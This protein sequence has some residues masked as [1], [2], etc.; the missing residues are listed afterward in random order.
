MRGAVDRQYIERCPVG[1]DV[2][3]VRTGIGLPEGPLRRCPACA[4]LVSSCSEE[5]YW[6]S[7]QEFDTSTGTLPLPGSEARQRKR[8]RRRL[9]IIETKLGMPRQ[10]IRLL[11]VGCSSGAFLRVAVTDGFQAE[12]VEPAPQAAQAARDAGLLV[13]QGR[14]EDLR[15]PAASFDAITL[16]EV[17]EHLKDPQSLLTECRRLLRGQGL[18]LIGT[19]NADS[20][21]ARLQG[22]RW[23]YFRIDQ[24][25]GHVS[26]FNPVSTRALAGRTGFRVEFIRTR[27]VSLCDPAS[28]SALGWRVWKAANELLSLPARWAG[29]GHDMLAVLRSG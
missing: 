11:D 23:E 2:S 12:G 16:F 25:G 1:C 3:L 9:A 10:R 14:L 15:L 19:G 26:F 6:E 21:T 27:R 5:R 20:W 22:P 18:L 8:S 17:I 28:V 4:Q 7:M 29:K 13:H 24:H